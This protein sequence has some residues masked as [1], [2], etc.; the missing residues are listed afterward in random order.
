M[1]VWDM[2]EIGSALQMTP[3]MTTRDPRLARVSTQAVATTSRRIHAL[4]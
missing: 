3:S 2:L 4:Q 1:T